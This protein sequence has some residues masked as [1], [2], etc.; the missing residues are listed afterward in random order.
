MGDVIPFPSTHVAAEARGNATRSGARRRRFFMTAAGAFSN[1][2]AAGQFLAVSGYCR[3]GIVVG[4]FDPQADADNHHEGTEI[5]ILTRCGAD[6]KPGALHDRLA[7]FG[8]AR[9]PPSLAP[10]SSPQVAATATGATPSSKSRR[11][12]GPGSRGCS[13]A[14]SRSPAS[15]SR[16]RCSICSPRLKRTGAAPPSIDCRAKCAPPFCAGLI[17]ERNS[18]ICRTGSPAALNRP[19][20]LRLAATLPCFAE[21]SVRTARRN[22]CQPDGAPPILIAMRRLSFD[23]TFDAAADAAGAA[24]AIT[25]A[26]SPAG[27]SARRN[28]GSTCTS[29]YWFCLEHVRAYN[30]AWNY[31]AGMSDAEIEAEIRHDT[32]WQR[33][34]WRLGDRHGPGYADRIRDHFGVFSGGPEEAG[35]A[36]RRQEQRD[37]GA[38]AAARA[39]GARAGARRFRNRAAL[40][41]GAAQGAVQGLVKLHHPDAHGGDKAAEEKLKIINQAYATLKASYFA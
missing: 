23:P 19:M 38:D 11:S 14:A 16:C 36:R 29:Y 20:R 24:C 12:A 37:Q 8:R 34:S 26:A 41:P 3:R 7:E 5:A 27:T 32:V 6:E 35:S 13:T 1:C 30:S 15:P 2:R 17:H 25:P 4:R 9:E 31:Y 40:Y 22:P 18:A 28:P 21:L 33:P 39:V 10:L